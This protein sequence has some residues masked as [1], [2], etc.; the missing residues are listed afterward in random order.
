MVF[1]YPVHP[2]YN[3]LCDKAISKLPNL[4]F[5]ELNRTHSRLI[6]ISYYGL[7]VT[8]QH[9]GYDMPSV[10]F[11]TKDD[12]FKTNFFNV[13]EKA[14]NPEIP[15]TKKHQ[16][17]KSFYDLEFELDFIQT[18]SYQILKFIVTEL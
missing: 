3:Q 6:Y 14:I 4:G 7:T 13:L 2:L 10:F 11:G 16:E 18:Y 1:E 5:I 17:L 9:E 12:F 8:V 15:I